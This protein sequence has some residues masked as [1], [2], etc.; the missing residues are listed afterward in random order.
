M[1]KKFKYKPIASNTAIKSQKVIMATNKLNNKNSAQ[2]KNMQPQQ[3]IK[4]TTFK[5]SK[6]KTL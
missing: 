6:K 4:T 3:Q 2:Q 5:K 1:I